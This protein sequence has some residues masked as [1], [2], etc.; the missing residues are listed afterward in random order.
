MNGVVQSHVGRPEPLVL[1]NYLTGTL[2]LV[3]FSIPA[4]ANGA[5]S[6]LPVGVGDWWY[7]TGG[8]LGSIVVIG[9][10]ILTRTIGALLFTLGIVAGQLIGSLFLDLVWPVP[11]TM[12]VWQTVVG[13]IVT[14]MA[15][16]LASLSG[17]KKMVKAEPSP[18]VPPHR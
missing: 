17:L 11:G 7:Y 18:E 12:V 5:L 8:I 2:A 4:I 6:R 9:G 10:A 1:T 15:L 14:L 13:V 16:V 3:I